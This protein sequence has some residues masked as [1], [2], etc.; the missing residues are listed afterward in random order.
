MAPDLVVL[1]RV[2]Q[3]TAAERTGAPRDR[4]EAAGSDFHE[5]VRAGFEAQ[6]AL[7]PQRW[8]VVD[9]SGTVDEVAAMID[10]AMRG[11]AVTVINESKDLD[12]AIRH[13]RIGREIWWELMLAAVVLLLLEGYLSCRFA[14]QASG[15]I[16][17][18]PGGAVSLTPANAGR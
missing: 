6:A 16:R 18:Q 10:E 14:R 12:A 9:G 17:W 1:L 13:G 3:E 4:I 5:R 11:A 7:E 8:V 15:S 2:D